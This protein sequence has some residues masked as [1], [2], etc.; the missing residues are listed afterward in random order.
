KGF[1][2]QK[3]KTTVTKLQQL[4]TLLASFK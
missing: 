3:L 2:E 1:N 4:L